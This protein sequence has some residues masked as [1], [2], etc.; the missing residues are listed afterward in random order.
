MIAEVRGY[1]LRELRESLGLTQIQLVEQVGISQ[2]QV[3]A[4]ERGDLENVKISTIR[5]YMRVVGVEL[6]VEC[7]VGDNRIQ[8]A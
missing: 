3:S 6:A 7:V 5:G 8:V 4:I 1:R 2:R